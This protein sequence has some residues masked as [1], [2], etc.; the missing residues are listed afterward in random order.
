MKN[1]KTANV[2]LILS[3]LLLIPLFF[4]R[5]HTPSSVLDAIFFLVQCVFIGSVA[6]WFAVTALFRKPLGISFHTELIPRNRDK[7]IGGIR[8]AI[9]KKLLTRETA[10]MM[11]ADLSVENLIYSFMN[12]EERRTR[13]IHQTAEM[14]AE[15]FM[16]ARPVL[17]ETGREMVVSRKEEIAGFICDSIISRSDILLDR[18]LDLA[19]KKLE[20]EKT[21][22]V[23]AA[24]LKTYVMEELAPGNMMI[25]LALLTG[26][27][28]FEHMAKAISR[29]AREEL[30]HLDRAQVYG[31]WNTSLR[32]LAADRRVMDM[33][34]A[35]VV[36]LAHT[37]RVQSI[38]CSLPGY[39]DE[40]VLATDMAGAME[41]G[42]YTVINDRETMQKIEESSVSLFRK[43]LSYEQSFA[44][45]EA[46]NIL[47]RFSK[48]KFNR[49]LYEKTADELGWIRINGAVV[50][51]IG[52]TI[53]LS[54][55]WLVEKISG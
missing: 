40:K 3:G 2:I 19:E 22:E 18:L 42:L 13:L 52:G 1:I 53:F 50:G 30:Q 47:K 45:A 37:D 7:I 17:L 24:R 6:D 33:L 27:V 11:V 41:Q 46:E 16:D 48:V 21:D 26:A 10:E 25:G 29:A 15:K 43:V 34:K 8:K 28:N 9:E 38:L 39:T 14:L 23:L 55:L 32:A 12:N 20:E 31:E 44:G 35:N 51:C 5:L 4:L 49:F 36:R 54:V